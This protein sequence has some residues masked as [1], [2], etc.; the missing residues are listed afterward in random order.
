MQPC[1]SGLN[2]CGLALVNSGSAMV[3]NRASATTI[4]ASLSCTIFPPWISNLFCWCSLGYLLSPRYSLAPKTAF[5]IPIAITE[6]GLPTRHSV[7]G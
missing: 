1:M 7:H 2:P 3:I 4:A 6:M 5:T